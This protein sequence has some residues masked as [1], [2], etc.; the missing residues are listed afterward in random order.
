MVVAELVTF[1]ANNAAAVVTTAALV[2]AI[3]VVGVA[4]SVSVAANSACVLFVLCGG[5]ADAINAGISTAVVMA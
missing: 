3:D 5:V 1:V 4:A 2:T